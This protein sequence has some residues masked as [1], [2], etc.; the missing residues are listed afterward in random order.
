MF[1]RIKKYVKK[2]VTNLL[3]G[4]AVKW[5]F[6]SIVLFSPLT[7]ISTVGMPVLLITA[8]TIH[9]GVIEYTSTLLL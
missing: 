8:A 1:Q 9:S 6:W 2:K 3:V 5:T 7:T 4:K